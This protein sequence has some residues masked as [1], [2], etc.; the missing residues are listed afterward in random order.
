M[1][2]E[3]NEILLSIVIPTYNRAGFLHRCIE[4]VVANIEPRIEIVI[5][6][7]CSPDNT[8]EV[9]K[10]FQDPRIRYFR[11]PVNLGAVRNF[12]FLANEAKGKYLFFLTDDDFLLTGGLQTV[13]KFILEYQPDGF[14]CGMLVY[15]IKNQAAYLYSAFKKTFVADPLDF[16][17]QAQ[18]F[19]NS[20]I[21]T[22]TC[23]RREV[24][25]YVLFEKNVSN[26][27]PSML[28]MAMSQKKLGYI[29]E[30]IAVHIWEN[31]VFWDDD[32]KPE[33]SSKLMA[34]RGDILNIMEDRLPTGFLK[35]SEKLIN[36]LSLNYPPITRFLTEDERR[37]RQVEFKMHAFNARYSIFVKK[38]IHPL[39]GFIRGFV[40]RTIARLVGRF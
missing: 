17:S 11:Q 5:S 7:N 35:E 2:T 37:E 9:V 1:K 31:E 27:Y 19:W 4:S 23:I 40:A 38:L 12:H 6:D 29:H 18:I 3:V 20:H 32:T 30:P 39:D 28:F 15:Q 24:L 8:Q 14:K 13:V 22:C 36:R 16:E 33:D 26:L 25:D 21:A 34:H 10:Q